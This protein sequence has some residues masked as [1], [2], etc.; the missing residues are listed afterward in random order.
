MPKIEQLLV[1]LVDVLQSSIDAVCQSLLLCSCLLFLG[2]CPS[3]FGG[4]ARGARHE[5]ESLTSTATAH[6]GLAEVNQ[7]GTGFT[8]T[9]EGSYV[10]AGNAMTTQ[11]DGKF[12]PVDAQ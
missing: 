3:S 4:N 10:G 7:G 8:S 6:E 12:P 1:K 11:P 5:D 9:A 2:R